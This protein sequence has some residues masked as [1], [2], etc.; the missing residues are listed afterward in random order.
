MP[1]QHDMD[2]ET[3]Q[4]INA[5][6]A[7]AGMNHPVVLRGLLQ[8]IILFLLCTTRYL[9]DVILSPR[10]V[11]AMWHQTALAMRWLWR[12]SCCAPAA[13]LFLLYFWG[14]LDCGILGIIVRWGLRCCILRALLVAMM[15][16][17]VVV[18]RLRKR[19]IWVPL[20]CWVEFTRVSSG[21]RLPHGAWQAAHRLFLCR[22]VPWAVRM[23][24]LSMTWPTLS[25][26]PNTPFTLRSVGQG[27]QD[28]PEF[29]TR[30]DAP[31]KC[32][33]FTGFPIEC[34]ELRRIREF[35]SQTMPRML[36][37]GY[38]GIRKAMNERGFPGHVWH[39]GHACPDPSKKSTR[40]DEDF[41]WNLFAQHAVDNANLAHCLVSCAEAE[42]VGAH[43]VRCT[44]TDACIPSCD[45]PDR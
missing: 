21:R 30:L 42:H 7:D 41:G 29:D 39:V 11:Q 36:D 15:D 43:H 22:A 23:C 2:D 12:A 24:L 19:H 10:V 37:A 45:G 27:V 4:A 40:N 16:D 6:T 31:D 13:S 32:A 38:R 35:N 28:S 3:T 26:A 20:A 34:D 1:V 44:R 9:L 17:T 14:S 5:E 25:V 8:C 18:A 33:S